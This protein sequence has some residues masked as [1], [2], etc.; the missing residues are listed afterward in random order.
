MYA[1]ILVFRQHIVSVVLV[2]LITIIA[3]L[4][5]VDV[6]NSKNLVVTK[7]RIDPYILT[8]QG[9]T[10]VKSADGSITTLEVQQ[11]KNIQIDDRIR[12]LANSAATIFW[13]DGSVTRLGEKTNIS[14]LE[15]KQGVNGSTQVDF[16]ISE[17]KSWSNLAR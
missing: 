3:F 16:S 9:K 8:T 11:K 14:V 1:F 15:I 4:L 5:F 7:E 13:T 10:F 12:T 6:S 17:G 2:A